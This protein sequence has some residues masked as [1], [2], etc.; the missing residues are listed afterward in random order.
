VLEEPLTSLQPP[1]LP[2][3]EVAEEVELPPETPQHAYDDSA[4]DYV[5][6]ESPLSMPA[7]NGHAAA[8]YFGAANE[9]A[10]AESV[11]PPYSS[12]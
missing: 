1:D 11:R 5:P 4:A 7:E 8:G 2:E 3:T 6:G 12:S 10:P 9:L